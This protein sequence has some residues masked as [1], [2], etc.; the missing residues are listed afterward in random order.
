[1]FQKRKNI[2]FPQVIEEGVKQH[3]LTHGVDHI[4]LAGALPNYGLLKD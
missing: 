2:D 1:M 3:C 4:H